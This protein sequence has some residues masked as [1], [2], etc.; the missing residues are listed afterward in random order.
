MYVKP[1]TPL[2][3]GG[4]L[5]DAIK[6]YRASFRSCWVISLIGSA[7][8]LAASI[9]MLSQAVGLTDGL[10]F[11][12]A[13]G[14]EVDPKIMLPR[15]MGMAYQ[16]SKVYVV[17]GL[18]SLVVFA[19]VFAQTSYVHRG[20]TTRGVGDSFIAALSR[21]PGMIV[22]SLI[23]VVAISLGTFLFFIPG[24]YLWGK[25]EFWF[26]AIFADQTGAID[27][28]GRSWNATAGNWWRSVTIISIALI[29]MFV[30][31]LLVY[32]VSGALIGVPL[33]MT[34]PDVTSL[35]FLV[36]VIVRGLVSVFIFP[37]YPAVM[38]STYH[39]MKLRREGSDLASRAQAL[40]SA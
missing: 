19:A 7:A 28:L 16:M 25:L 12:V 13:R 10:G 35:V 37:M 17:V 26:A 32:V 5:D 1:V 8:M 40:Q 3:V 21:L 39:D 38:L 15:I 2:T 31:Q 6:L 27:S 36:P 20:E 11:G 33:L 9:W 30:L 14:T 4:V 23:F 29:M 22:G 34:H 24:V 18:T